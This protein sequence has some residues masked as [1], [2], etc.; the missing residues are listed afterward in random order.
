M[1]DRSSIRALRLVNQPPKRKRQYYLMNLT[2]LLFVILLLAGLFIAGM[3]WGTPLLQWWSGT[4]LSLAERLATAAGPSLEE[5]QRLLLEAGNYV[6]FLQRETS[7]LDAAARRFGW[8]EQEF[9]RARRLL[10]EL[11]PRFEAVEI[12]YLGWGR[13]ARVTYAALKK[14]VDGLHEQLVLTFC[15]EFNLVCGRGVPPDEAHFK[16][17]VKPAAKPPWKQVQGGVSLSVLFFEQISQFCF[18]LF[19]NL[20]SFGF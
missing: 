18:C 17:G 10:A 8:S 5:E 7:R 20:F 13:D 2:L 4:S 3:L 14:E 6:E 16:G 1:R 12:G 19:Q 11:R 15:E 9:A